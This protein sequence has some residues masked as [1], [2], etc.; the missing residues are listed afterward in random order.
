MT[1]NGVNHTNYNPSVDP[2]ENP[3]PASIGWVSL[4]LC[5][6]RAHEQLLTTQKHALD[7]DLGFVAPDAYQTPDIICH[8]NATNAALSVPVAA[9]SAI[10]LDWRPFYWPHIGTIITYLANCGS[11]CATVDKTTLQFFKIDAVGITAP[12]DPPKWATDQLVAQQNEWTVTIPSSVAAGNYVMRHEIIALH[13]AENADGAQNY[14]QCI[15]LQVTGSGT[16]KPSGTLGEALYKETDPG[17]LFN[18]Y[19]KVNSYPIP[20]PTLIAGAT[21]RSVDFKA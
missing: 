2:Y 12:G 19:T 17:I 11:S 5:K 9:G 7:T 6:L 16:A 15:N 21:K 18:P 1:A 13:S 8:K 10:K 4:F 20:G 3:D 14:P